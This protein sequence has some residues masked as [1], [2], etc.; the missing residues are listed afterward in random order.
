M[1]QYEPFAVLGVALAV[2]LLIGLER[3]QSVQSHERSETMFLGGVRTYPLFSL[4]GAVSVLLS[5]LLG[6]WIVAASLAAFGAFLAISYHADVSQS[7]D[8]GMT[9]EAAFLVTFLLGALA[10]AR[11]IV[12]PLG[13]RV[14]VVSSVAIAV[15]VLLSAKPKLHAFLQKVS[16]DDV[17]AVLKFLVAAIVV[18]PLLPNQTYGPLNVVNPFKSGLM[19]VLI[20]GL[21]FVGYVAIRAVGPGRG[22]GLMGIVGGLASSTAVT[23]S[24]SRLAGKEP[25]LAA[26]CALAIVSASTIMFGRVL[27]MVAVV[28]PPMVVALAI[29]LGA[30]T[31]AGGLVALILLL[32]SRRDPKAT[33]E[34]KV[35]NPFELWSAIKFGLIFTAVIFVSKAAT[36]YLGSGGTYLASLLAGTTDV[37]AITLSMANLAKE[38]SVTADVAS[39]SIMLG[40]G[41][42]TVV[43]AGL[44]L[45]IGGWVFGRRVLPA[46]VAMMIGG[47]LG[48]AALWLSGFGA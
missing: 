33:A 27:A 42:N 37:D 24:S 8:R 7:K 46:F 26:S 4:A 32:R 23:I 43:K 30:M 12:E 14:M 13:H 31:L 28:H 44:A 40:I 39:T 6:A 15:T 16:K 21:S 47:G 38:A 5:D 11:G 18:L 34:V 48:V 41:A 29:P 22:L 17:F 35:S 19:I 20:A 25:V 3:E 9:S 1:E 36:I 10:A 2:G 45:S